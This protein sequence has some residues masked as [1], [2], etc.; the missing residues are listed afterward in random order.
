MTVRPPSASSGWVLATQDPPA[1]SSEHPSVGGTKPAIIGYMGMRWCSH[2]NYMCFVGMSPHHKIDDTHVKIWLLTPPP[3]GER[4]TG[5]WTWTYEIVTS[6][7]NSIMK[8]GVA[9]GDD[10]SQIQGVFGKLVYCPSLKSLVWTRRQDAK[11][12][13]IRLANMT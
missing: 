2:P 13:L 8:V 9:A 10:A 5:T 3:V 1:T 6:G 12:Q 7:D 4:K 11:G